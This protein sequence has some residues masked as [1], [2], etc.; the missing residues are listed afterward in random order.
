MARPK[1][2]ASS[3]VGNWGNKEEKEKATE[4][5]E[6]LKGNDDKL[7]EIPFELKQDEYAQ[8]YYSYLVNELKETGVLSNLDIPLLVQTADC[9]S[10][11]Y[12]ADQKINQEGLLVTELDRYG[13]EKVRK[14]PIVEVKN[15]Y[16]TQF[17]ALSTQLGLSPSSRAALAELKL[18]KKEE[19]NDPVIEILK[20]VG[21]GKV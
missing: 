9:L 13:N 4:L 16:L 7:D 17:R 19:E 5:E 3:R 2:P 12:Q 8:Y 11:M 10:K 14:H 20:Q 1:K 18:A 6:K 21:N 15:A